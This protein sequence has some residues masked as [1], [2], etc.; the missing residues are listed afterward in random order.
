MLAIAFLRRPLPWSLVV[1]AFGTI[2]ALVVLFLA[3]E[4]LPHRPFINQ[5]Y[6]YLA[7]LIGPYPVVSVAINRADRDSRCGWVSLV[8]CEIVFWCGVV[9]VTL[10]AVETIP[11]VSGSRPPDIPIS[12]LAGGLLVLVQYWVAVAALLFSS[13]RRI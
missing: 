3:H 13:I 5:W 10:V 1:L 7:L 11:I 6:F 2:S 12:A 8:M 4:A 9:I